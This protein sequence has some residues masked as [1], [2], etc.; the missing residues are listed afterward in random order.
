MPHKITYQEP[1]EGF[2]V[3][4]IIAMKENEADQASG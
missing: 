2:N 3:D 1:A 4:S